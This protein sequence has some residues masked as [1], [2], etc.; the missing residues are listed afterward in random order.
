M[1]MHTSTLA[2]YLLG[3]VFLLLGRSMLKTVLRIVWQ[4]SRFGFSIGLAALI[5]VGLVGD[6]LSAW[7]GRPQRRLGGEGTRDVRAG[8]PADG[9]CGGGEAWEGREVQ[10]R[11]ERVMDVGNDI[12]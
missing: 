2:S 10:G 4:P 6:S 9:P 3:R 7:P 11:V 5:V 1:H 8:G 12:T